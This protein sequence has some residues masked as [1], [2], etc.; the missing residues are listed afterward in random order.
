MPLLD[1]ASVEQVNRTIGTASKA[2][3]MRNHAD[4]RATLVKFAQQFPHRLAVG[5][6]KVAGRFVGEQNEWIACDRARRQLAVVGHQTIARDSVW[7]GTT[8][9]LFLAPS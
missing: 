6:A 7:R 3:V 5:R 2:R 8:C 4:G 1:N 9:R